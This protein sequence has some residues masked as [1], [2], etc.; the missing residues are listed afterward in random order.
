MRMRITGLVVIF[1][2]LFSGC[3]ASM[4][5]GQVSV[6]KPSRTETNEAVWLNYWQDQFDGYKGNVIPPGPEYPEASRQAY[7][8]AKIEWDGKVQNAQGKTTLLVWAVGGVVSLV[9]FLV[10]L[11][12]IQSA[13][14]TDY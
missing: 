10:L 13:G 5:P 1:A 7:Q 12:N 8:R 3:A 4:H 14:D 11:N 2:L 9:T 6:E